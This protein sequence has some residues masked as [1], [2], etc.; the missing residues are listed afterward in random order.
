MSFT[1][2]N[3]DEPPATDVAAMAEGKISVTP[4]HIDRSHAPGLQDLRGV[5]RTAPPKTVLAV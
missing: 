1:G 4:L 3:Q 5:G 2:T